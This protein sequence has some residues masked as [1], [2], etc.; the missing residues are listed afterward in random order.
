M[1]NFHSRGTYNGLGTFP[2]G[3]TDTGVYN[4]QGNITLPKIPKGDT[5]NSS[6]VVTININ[7]G[8]TLYTGAAGAQGFNFT[9]SATAND[10]INVILT[11]AAAVDQGLN[12]IKTNVTISEIS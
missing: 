12:L 10:I 9:T 4:I 8:G 11:S 5:A 3:V 6:V 7:G 2:L 1:T